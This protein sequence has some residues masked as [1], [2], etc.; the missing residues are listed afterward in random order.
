MDLPHETIET[1]PKRLNRVPVSSEQDQ[2]SAEETDVSEHGIFHSCLTILHSGKRVLYFFYLPKRHLT[3]R[4]LHGGSGR[5]R[6]TGTV[7]SDT[8]AAG[9]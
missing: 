7:L 8:C 9:K 1:R 2:A 3:V 5:K 4:H 6:I